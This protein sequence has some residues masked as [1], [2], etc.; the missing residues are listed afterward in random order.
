[1]STSKLSAKTNKEL[2]LLL[3]YRV[4]RVE[5]K[6]KDLCGSVD[7]RAT[8]AQLSGLVSREEFTP[9]KKDVE[10]L[11]GIIKW[12]ALLV[13]AAVIGSLLKMVLV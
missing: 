7:E 5:E 6:L 13:I 8:L 11:K 3:N 1:M 4:E 9:V 10:D 12:T 2:L